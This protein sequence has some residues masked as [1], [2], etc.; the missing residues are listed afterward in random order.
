MKSQGLSLIDVL[1][2][3]T[4]FSIVF[5]GI[6]GAYQLSL[7]VIVQS[8]ARVTATA[9][10]N[11]R[12]E[13]IRNLPYKQVGTDPHSID[14]P[15]GSVPQVSSTTQNGI[16][17]AIETRIIYLNDCF[18]GPRDSQ[19]PEAPEVDSCARDYKRVEIKT[20]WLE[21]GQGEV[22]LL[23]DIAPKNL[24]QEEEEC[25]GAAAGVLS[26]SVMDALGQPV[27]SPL[28][29][30]VDPETGMTLTAYQPIGGEHDFVLSPAVYKVKVSK[31]GY[32]V[33]QSFRDGD[34][35][36]GKIIAEPSKSHP[37]VYEGQ[38]AETG[39]SID[40]LSAMT[41]ETRGT[42]EQEYP[43]VHNVNFEM[44]GSKTVGNDEEG[45]PI[46]K[47]SQEKTA[48][49]EAEIT[50]S[51]LEWDSYSFYIDSPDYHLIGV[52]SPPETT[53]TQPVTLLPDSDTTV[54]LILKAEN[55]L[56]VKVQNASTALPIFGAEVRL[57]NAVLGYEEIQPTDEDGETFFIPLKE[58]SYELEAA[59]MGYASSSDSI[60][61]SGDKST[62]INL[63][64]LQ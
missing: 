44:Q 7:K 6:F 39:F 4:I 17:Y 64:P 3:I 24:N 43:L 57:Y 18:D 11:E 60:Y 56:S 20:S 8:K 15:S 34:V 10:A 63:I 9:I 2:G 40:K 1:V 46:Y 16:E 48:N 62:A 32:S 29:E 55:T 51:G 58:D 13:S 31:T 49:G 52:E 35:Y 19:C 53:T 41:I 5:L 42:K 33:S 28:I 27:D 59:M 47:Y 12:I 23:T 25:T 37:S 26:V 36:Q 45:S 30:I 54:R 14:E 21:P 38:L 50:I 22:V 61:V